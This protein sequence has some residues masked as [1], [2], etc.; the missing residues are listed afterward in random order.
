MPPVS[1]TVLLRNQ[2]LL[3]RRVLLY[4]GVLYYDIFLLA[5]T[6]QASE[7]Y[8]E[9]AAQC[10]ANTIQGD[11]SVDASADGTTANSFLPKKNKPTETRY[12]NTN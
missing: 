12:F 8:H 10:T 9:I 6:M 3:L 7:R 4:S 2:D 5:S 11:S 1:R